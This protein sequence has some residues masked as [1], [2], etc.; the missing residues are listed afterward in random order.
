ME[1]GKKKKQRRSKRIGIDGKR[2]SYVKVRPRKA[3]F[4]TRLLMSC[5]KKASTPFLSSFFLT[6]HNNHIDGRPKK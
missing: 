5:R 1:R 4:E 3:G 6:K 2:E